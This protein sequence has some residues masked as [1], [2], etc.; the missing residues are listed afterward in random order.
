LSAQSIFARLRPEEAISLAIFAPMAFALAHRI[1]V[2]PDGGPAAGYPSQL[3]RLVALLLVA[4]FFFWLIRY[5]PRWELVRDAMPF[6]FC[7]NVYANL[8]DLIMFYGAPDITA[9]LHRWDVML[10]GVE[11]SLWAERF[12][13][14][15]LTDFFTFCYWLFY[16]CSPLLGL[17]LYVRKDWRAFRY[18]MVS[19]VLC[20][21]IGY[22]GYV[23]WPAAAPR[24]AI[25]DLY[26]VPLHGW[27]PFLDY[28][29]T[30]PAAVPL[31]V[32]GA[33][34]SLHCAVALLALLLAWKHMRWYFW[35]Q[36]PFGVGLIVG[37]VY[38][39]HHWAVDILAGF[40]VTFA[41]FWAGPAIEDAW[42][43]A[44]G[45]RGE[46]PATLTSERSLGLRREA[47]GRA[48]AGG[49]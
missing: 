7:A 37:T 20:L 49:S 48:S 8:H 12:I 46:R 1:G 35:V 11:P 5:R 44:A 15:F 36:I 3:A 47:E 22:I 29:R 19:V 24:L 30:A 2:P 10:F 17:L 33:F 26:T 9:T 41:A 28:S 23:S 25:A 31:T 45:R 21:F 14:P 42:N 6:L 4:G 16:V 13:H 18:T 39:R 27:S 43:R 32:R 34:P 38:L 40:V